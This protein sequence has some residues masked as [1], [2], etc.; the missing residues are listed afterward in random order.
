MNV[1]FPSGKTLHNWSWSKPFHGVQHLK[2]SDSIV[3]DPWCTVVDYVTFA[4]LYKHVPGSSTYFSRKP[5]FFSSAAEARVAGM[6]W[7]RKLG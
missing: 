7:L 2:I 1:T 6:E 3:D 4:E 5:E